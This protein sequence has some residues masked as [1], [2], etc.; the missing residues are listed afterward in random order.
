MSKMLAKER[1]T[2]VL[3]ISSTGFPIYVIQGSEG[4]NEGTN[5]GK[6]EEKE[7]EGGDGGGTTEGTAEAP[8]PQVVSREEYETILRRL[9]A[10]DQAKGAAEKRLREIDDA[11]KSE[12][13]KAKRDLEEIKKRAEAAEAAAL[14]AK[15]ANE[16]LKF[17]GFIWHDPEAVLR[18]VDMEMISVDEDGKVTGVKDALNKLAK[19]KAYLLKGKQGDKDKSGGAGTNGASGHNPAGAGDTT[20]ANKQRDKLRQKYKLR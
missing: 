6:P 1:M 10:A 4:E 11:D 12:L 15:L 9:N 19:D 3:G 20:D 8:Q 13:E 17:P 2:R 16:I 7:K 5:E 14:Q 18:L